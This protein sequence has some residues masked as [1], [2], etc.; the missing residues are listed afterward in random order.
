MTRN[1]QSAASKLG[2]VAF[3]EKLYRQ[4][5]EGEQTLEREYGADGILAVIEDR[6]DKTRRQMGNL[7]RRGVSF[8]TYLEIG[9][10]RG[11][12]S[13]VMENDLGVHGFA[14]DISYHSLRSACHYAERFG[15]E[16]LPIRLCCDAYNLPFRNNSLPFV[17]GYQTLHHFPDPTPVLAEIYR[18]MAPGSSF[19]FD[20]EPVKRALHLGIYRRRPRR[21]GQ[22][23]RGSVLTRALRA[24][25]SDVVHTECEYG[26]V[27]NEDISPSMWREYLRVFDTV[28]ATVKS[29]VAGRSDLHASGRNA[30]SLLSA[31]TGG[32]VEGLC[33]KTSGQTFGP[34]SIW[35]RLGCPN[36]RVKNALGVEDRAP[37][38]FHSDGAAHCTQ[39]NLH[40]PAREGILFLFAEPDQRYLYPDASGGQ[41]RPPA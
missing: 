17:F 9:A 26:I 25:F 31:L 14:M 15:Q 6:M 3:R 39:C 38:A 32:S 16:A 21:S 30:R 7:L 27:E 8:G 37:L 4:Q 24:V 20:E 29:P 5:V 2:E 13:L 23:T 33:W 1:R 19:F 11:Q 18:V 28:E 40:F 22:T 35:A 12:R 10:E 41:G 34:G 36:C